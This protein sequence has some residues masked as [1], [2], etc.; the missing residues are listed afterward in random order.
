MK[1]SRV[2]NLASNRMLLGTTLVVA[3][4]VIVTLNIQAHGLRDN[5]G[6]TDDAMRLVL[7]RDLMSGRGWYDQ[8]VTRL[9][10][11]HGV[12]MHWSR[13]VDA[14]LAGLTWLFRPFVSQ[15]TAEYWTRHVWPALWTIP[16]IG[17]ALAIARRVGGSTAIFILVA[18]CATNVQ[19]YEQF[20]P[21]R[22]DHHNVQ[23]VMTLIAAACALGGFA[24]ERWAWVAGAA[25]GLG[26]AVGIE[27]LPF[28]ALIGASYGLRAAFDPEEA[29]ASRNYG[30]GLV[31]ST[32]FFFALETPPTRW[33]L[34]FCDA[35]G[36][37]LVAGILVAGLGLGAFCQWGMRYSRA[38][39]LVLLG[40]LGV[41]AVGTY[42]GFNPGCV[43]GPFGAVDP[44]VIPFWFNNIEELLTWPQ[45]LRFQPETG[46]PTVAA[47]VMSSAAA[48][49]LL[50]RRRKTLD[51]TTLT[52][53]AA[54]FLA[55]AAAYHAFR[56]QDYVFWL[57]FPVL[58]SALAD[59]ADRWI[60]S[61]AIPTLVV[62]M[63][64]SPLAIGAGLTAVAKAVNPQIR[65][66]LAAPNRESCVIRPSY[67]R[68]AA[69]PGGVV[70][71]EIDFGPFILAY[72]PD[73]VLAAPYHRMS[74][75]ILAAHQALDASPD[76]AE[77]KVRAL[78]VAYV[79]EC[80][81]YIRRTGPDSLDAGLRKG[82]V[83][84][85]LEPLS[86][87]GAALQIYQVLPPAPAKAG[88]KPSR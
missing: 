23:I 52:A 70:L 50:W 53:C 41:V 62:G 67:R 10:P 31:L 65:T 48:I 42:L 87:P 29:K 46:L 78:N 7:V 76:A 57:G 22:I 45:L 85:W 79:V 47:G 24:R 16:A 54:A 64:I 2:P 69:L 19:M 30:G 60:K 33:G 4:I 58:A 72:T 68:L 43:R 36:W 17:G 32:L 73:S 55:T 88:A 80:P 81:A 74:W 11:P 49:Y 84:S 63:A 1:F 38:V 3:A 77:Q 25:T 13:L 86:K 34:S 39:R 27:A 12:Y 75:G 61:S 14:G 20:R 66:V 56:M 59:M 44:R 83:P 18:I 71:S 40:V 21:G 8:L 9:Q 15:D 82:Q 51:A 35:I 6:D 26:L 28:Q 37:N 5:L